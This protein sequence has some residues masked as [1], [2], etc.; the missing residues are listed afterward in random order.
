MQ[1]PNFADVQI[2]MLSSYVFLYP[3][4]LKKDFLIESLNTNTLTR[5]GCLCLDRIKFESS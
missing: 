4:K 5:G 2:M 1:V 3:K